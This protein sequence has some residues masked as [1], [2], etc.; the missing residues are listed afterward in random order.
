MG[1]LTYFADLRAARLIDELTKQLA[2]KTYGLLRETSETR[3][4]TMTHAE[5]RG[6]LWAK[7]RRIVSAEVAV[8][9]VAQPSLSPWALAVLTERTHDRLVRTM[10]ADLMRDPVRHVQRRRAA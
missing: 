8:T 4:P 5:A 9:A 7:A 10:L 6:Y 3:V 2:R 1:L